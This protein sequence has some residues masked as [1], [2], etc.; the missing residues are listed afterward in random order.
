MKH[1]ALERESRF[2]EM[3]RTCRPDMSKAHQ[4]FCD[5]YLTPFFGKPDLT[6]NYFLTIGQNPRVMFAAHSD[7]VHHV[8]GLQKIHIAGDIVKLHS[9]SKSNCLGADCT[10]GIHIILEMIRANI[11]GAYA[12]FAAEEI[13]CIGSSDF[14]KRR[15]GETMGIDFVISLDRKGYDS[16]I[17][18]QMGRRIASDTFAKS[19]AG[20]LDLPLKA[21]P[22]GAYT[23]SNEFR[24][25][26]SECTNLSVGYFGQHTSA[27]Y[28]DLSFLEKLVN[29]MIN[30]DWS[31]LIA[32]RDCKAL[33]FETIGAHWSKYQKMKKPKSGVSNDSV[34]N[35]RAAY[36]NSKSDIPAYDAWD[37]QE[38]SMR[39]LVKQYPHAIA[40][41][42]EDQG[43]NVDSMCDDLGIANIGRGSNYCG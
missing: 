3:I 35:F 1:S 19:L 39:D 41:W 14:V 4:S 37:I 40:D 33:E 23:D 31:Q 27:E 26:I 38:M 32:A 7:T 25:H 11:P 15:I 22:S 10:A 36:L 2:I 34:L 29:R 13:G 9:K 30:A 42:L 6:G 16:I 20:I 8:G 24:N 17:T 43:M 12:I 18:H 28:Q 5:K 21:D